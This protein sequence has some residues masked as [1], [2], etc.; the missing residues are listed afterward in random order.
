VNKLALD[1][2]GATADKPGSDAPE[3]P[4]DAKSSA[5]HESS[6]DYPAI[7][8]ILDSKTRVIECADHIQW[9]IQKR[10]G[11]RW[12]SRYFCRTKA[13]LLLYAEPITPELLA[14]PDYFPE[15]RDWPPDEGAAIKTEKA[16]A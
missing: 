4:G 10:G 1:L 14:L 11:R 8:A 6:D 9:I 2:T 3:C 7:V 15:W 16:S 13:G 12:Y 5:A